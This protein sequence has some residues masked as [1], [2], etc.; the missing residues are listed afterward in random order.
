MYFYFPIQKIFFTQSQLGKSAVKTDVG[1]KSTFQSQTHDGLVSRFRVRKA[2]FPYHT[3]HNCF[4][5]TSAI[6]F[7]RWPS[8]NVFW[9]EYCTNY[10][11]LQDI[12]FE[13]SIVRPP[14][15][16][17]DCVA[18]CV[19]CGG[20][21]FFFPT[22]KRKSNQAQFSRHTGTNRGGRHTHQSYKKK[23]NFPNELHYICIFA[24]SKFQIVLRTYVTSLQLHNNSDL[25]IN[26]K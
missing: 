17:S 6:R 10:L 15:M 18:H 9:T 2:I 19:T 1:L 23:I 21:D 8:N 20:A 5:N 24:Q 26:Q 11:I 14:K 13:L 12:F 3:A 25:R 22:I 4:K 7:L 16:F